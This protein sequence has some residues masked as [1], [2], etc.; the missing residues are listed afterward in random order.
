M[1]RNSHYDKANN[2]AYIEISANTNTF[3][4]EMIIKDNYEVDFRRYNSINSL[5]GFYIELYEPGFNESEK[6]VSTLTINSILVN[7]DII[8]SSYVNGFT[9]LTINSF[10][11]IVSPGYKI[12]ENPQNLLYLPTTSDTIHRITILL[13]DQ[14]GN[15]L[16][17]QG[18]NF[19]I[20]NTISSERD[21]KN[22]K[23]HQFYSANTKR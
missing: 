18:H 3:K 20:K 4:S 22:D 15:E 16:N 7:I 17:L 13:T 11:P 23:L 14:N 2:K 9:Q 8:S 5:T 12:I 21:F 10:F 6:M 1:R 19:Y